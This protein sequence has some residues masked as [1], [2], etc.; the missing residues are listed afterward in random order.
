VTSIAFVMELARGGGPRNVFILS[1]WLSESG[2]DC[3]VQRMWPPIPQEDVE[4]YGARMV[5]R[6]PTNTPPATPVRTARTH[7]LRAPPWAITDYS[8][9]FQIPGSIVELPRRP[10]ADV[11]I[12]TSWQSAIPTYFTS[13]RMAA[14][15]LYF[16]QADET[17]FSRFPP[18]RRLAEKTYRLPVTRFTQSMWLKDFLERAYGGEVHYIGMGIDHEAFYPRSL[19]RERVVFTVARS[20]PNKGF[21]VFVQAMKLLSARQKDFQVLIAGER[22]MVEG[23]GF[24]FPFTYLGWINDDHLLADLYARSIF[25]NTG[26]QEALPMPPLEAMASGSSVVVSDIPGAR[27]YSRNGVNCLLTTPGNPRDVA[28]KVEQLLES[29]QLRSHIAHGAV[30]TASSYTWEAAVHRLAALVQS[31]LP[32]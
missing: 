2:Y 16:V 27:E 6:G 5:E 20:D 4:T 8:V 3:A 25:V 15:M 14:P 10:R 19:P 26:L 28:D 32:R 29:D 9:A 24:G 12:A 7:H 30:E 13:R 23:S 11:Y 17:T 1:K 31:V 18:F 21:S 22:R